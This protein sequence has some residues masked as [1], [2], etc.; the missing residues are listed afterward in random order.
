MISLH[1]PKRVSGVDAAQHLRESEFAMARDLLH[2]DG[3][4]P[5]FGR[6]SFL[7]RQKAL[8]V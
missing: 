8:I 2:L 3:D 4:R 5:K 6:L 7:S 1:V